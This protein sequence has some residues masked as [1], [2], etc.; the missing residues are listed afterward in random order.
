MEELGGAKGVSIPDEPSETETDFARAT[1]T[2]SL[3]EGILA[4][5]GT[6]FCI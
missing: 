4:R 6:D 3:S 2:C 5:E 1:G